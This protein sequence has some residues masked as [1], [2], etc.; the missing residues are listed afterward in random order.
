M[1]TPSPTASARALPGSVAAVIGFLVFTEFASGFVQ[2]YY[3]PLVAAIAAQLGIGTADINWFTTTFTLASAI[4]VPLLSK[5]GDRYGPRRM[6]RIG[7]VSVFVATIVIA[8]APNFAVLMLGRVLLAPLAVWLPLEIALIHNRI[9]GETARRAITFLVA[10]LAAGAVVGSLAAGGVSLIT[11]NLTVTLLAPSVV[12]LI[13]LYAVFRKIP[14]S[15]TLTRNSIDYPGF[16]GLAIVVAAL[17][18]GLGQA[19]AHGFASVE[20]LLPVGVAVVVLAGWIPWQLRVTSPAIDLRVVTSRRLGPLYLVSFL[21]GL[22]TYG[23]QVPLTTFLAADP[24]AAGYGFALPAATLA[25][26]AAGTT[27]M[28]TIGSTL[29]TYIARV[30]T[31]RGVLILGCVIAGVSYLLQALFHTELWQT[32][33][34]VL[35]AWGAIGFLLGAT[36]AMIAE[37]A[38]VDATGIAAGVYNT[39]RTVGGA[40]AGALVSVLLSSFVLPTLGIPSETGYVL[41][42][43]GS[44]VAFGV[45]AVVLAMMRRTAAPAAAAPVA[46]RATA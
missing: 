28:A 46:E 14:E 10:V 6:L 44:A 9:T 23:N 22:I 13:A 8:L 18:W 34:F 37:N 5:L 24:G 40:V 33:L 36:P 21:F 20:V 39:L 7:V 41:V 45:A 32:T 35:L 31:L 27:A 19:P 2:G 4:V 43:V 16:A 12:L 25:L 26:V 38:P 15:V 11:S 30:I 42:W 29:S 1:S 3:T 17:L